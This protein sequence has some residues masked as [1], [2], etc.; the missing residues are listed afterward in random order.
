MSFPPSVKAAL[1]ISSRLL[2]ST[3]GA[4]TRGAGSAA[5]RPTAATSGAL[6]AIPSRKRRS[7]AR[8]GFVSVM[9]SC[10]PVCCHSDATSPRSVSNREALLDVLGLLDLIDHGDGVVFERDAAAVV[11]GQKNVLSGS[12]CPGSLAR[13]EIG[14]GGQER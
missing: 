7:T 12:E 9:M 8:E 2:V 1:W 10:F 3:S 13:M 5:A 14:G 4:G 11:R 6:R